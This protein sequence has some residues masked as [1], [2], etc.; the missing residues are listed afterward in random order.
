MDNRIK[1]LQGTSMSAPYVT[2]AIACI[3]SLD[4]SMTAAEVRSLLMVEW[5]RNKG[6]DAEKHIK[7]N[8]DM[9][10][11]GDDGFSNV[12]K[13][14]LNLK[15]S[16]ELA[17]LYVAKK[18]EKN[19][20]PDK[21]SQQQEEP[22]QPATQS[23]EPVP[24]TKDNPEPEYDIS[25]LIDTCI[26][27]LVQEYGIVP[28][29]FGFFETPISGAGNAFDPLETSGMLF[30][31]VYDYDDDGQQELLVMRNEPLYFNNRTVDTIH[32]EMY[33]FDKD[34][35]TCSD[36]MAFTATNLSCG[37][38]WRS[39]T[40][41]RYS[42]AAQQL[43]TSIG[44]ELYSQFNSETTTLASLTY[45][46]NVLTQINAVGYGEWP[47][48]DEYR[49]TCFFVPASYEGAILD[50]EAVFEDPWKINMNSEEEYD[51]IVTGRF[52]D[53]AIDSA[54]LTVQQIRSVYNDYNGT[55]GLA[56]DSQ[57]CY[58]TAK[59]CYASLI[60]DITE[61]GSITTQYGQAQQTLVR[62]D[63]LGSLDAYR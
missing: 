9:V 41:F 4:S 46:N 54:G 61:L 44:L 62:T 22:S 3:W 56:R 13:P 28:T 57:Y 14:A 49:T 60:D 63:Y 30:A 55:G 17:T 11:I 26:K 15:A 53:M 29:G 8:N 48:S 52:G 33:E 31:D 42:N 35:Y 47:G 6:S 25:A 2:G 39:L 37:G 24:V 40:V 34:G 19:N 27:D 10:Q 16:M 18:H 50:M 58:M 59:D 5:P 32:L 36:R 43:K 45:T 7:E 51:E 12:T 38:Y 23:H 1:S 20:V 21:E